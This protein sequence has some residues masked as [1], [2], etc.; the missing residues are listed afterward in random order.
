MAE[1]NPKALI[2]QF[3]YESVLT[4]KDLF[5]AL[6]QSAFENEGETPFIEDTLDTRPDYFPIT[7][8]LYLELPQFINYFKQREANNLDNTWIVKPWNLARGLD[9][10]V[11]NNVDTVIRLAESG[12]K[13]I[14]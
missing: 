3:P 9:V 6:V 8:N 1:Q 5:A 11:T 10:F 13:V 2:N 14:F 7:F 4:V 12:P